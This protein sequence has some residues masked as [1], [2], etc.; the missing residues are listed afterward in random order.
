M[1]DITVV[2]DI[3]MKIMTM[4]VVVEVTVDVKILK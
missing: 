4:N 1:N 3:I 2:D